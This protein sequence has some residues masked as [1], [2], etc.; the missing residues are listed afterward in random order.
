[1]VG[2]FRIR[3]EWLS[4]LVMIV[5]ARQQKKVGVACGTSLL[6]FTFETDMQNARCGFIDHV[7]CTIILFQ[8]AEYY[9]V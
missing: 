1:M 7:T 4:R 3:S 5:E 2:I 6:T 8:R 9:I